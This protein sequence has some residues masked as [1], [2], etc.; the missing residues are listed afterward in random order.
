MFADAEFLATVRDWHEAKTL[1]EG[2]FVDK[3]NA[4]L[5]ARY[6][7]AEQE[8]FARIAPMGQEIQ[9][10]VLKDPN[11]KVPA[12]SVNEEGSTVPAYGSKEHYEGFESSLEGKATEAEVK[13]RIAAARG[14]AVHPVKA[15]KAPK[16]TPKVRKVTAST[17]MGRE[18]SQ[19][20][21]TRWVD[22]AVISGREP[23]IFSWPWG[24]DAR[25]SVKVRAPEIAMVCAR[26]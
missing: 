21:P 25:N 18:K 6:E 5:E 11:L 22:Q 26:P 15:V 2:G 23:M 1:A 3:G 19:D 14:Q 4:G 13:G 12:P 20:G 24:A 10:K 8:I 9:V 7:K 17:G 16:K